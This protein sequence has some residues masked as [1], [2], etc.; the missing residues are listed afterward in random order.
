MQL[1]PGEV[2]RFREV[3]PMHRNILIRVL[4]PS[5]AVVMSGIML[6]LA[7]GQSGSARDTLLLVWF[8]SAIVLP[9]LIAFG[10]RLTTVVTDRR[11]LARFVPFSSKSIDL[12]AVESAEAVKYSP[13]ADA[14]GW[15][16]KFSKKFGTVL[17][18]SG[19]HGVFVNHIK[20]GKTKKLLLGSERPGELAEAIGVLP[21]S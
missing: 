16:V 6:P 17:N 18:V 21:A 19:E 20:D 8:G 12:G 14:G 15:G 3:Q 1:Q 11:V 7:F 10:L 13:I 5:E 9:L 4:M 2:E